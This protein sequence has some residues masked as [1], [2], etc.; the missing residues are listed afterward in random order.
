MKTSLFKEQM[1]VTSWQAV[2]DIVHV[3]LLNQSVMWLSYVDFKDRFVAFS[4][5]DEN[6]GIGYIQEVVNYDTRKSAAK[7][8]TDTQ[9]N[10]KGST[11]TD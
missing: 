7:G 8:F 11:R 2:S 5:D 3:Y 9:E 6:I 10:G 1:I 4:G